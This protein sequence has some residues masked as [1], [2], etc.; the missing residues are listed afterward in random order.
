VVTVGVDCL[1]SGRQPCNN[2]GLGLEA[3]LML[4]RPPRELAGGRRHICITTRPPTDE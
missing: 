1:Q 2:A 4:A 3:G